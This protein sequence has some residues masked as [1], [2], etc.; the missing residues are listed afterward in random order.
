MEEIVKLFRYDPLTGNLYWLNPT[1]RALKRQRNGLSA[2][3]L[4][5]SGYTR[6]EFR[7]K[8]YLAHRIVF[9]MHHGYVPNCIDHIN[10][11]PSDNRIENLREATKTQNSANQKMRGGSSRF[12]GAWWCKDKKKWRASIKANGKQN[13]IGY[14]TSELDAAK[15]Y[16]EAALKY[17]GEFARLNEI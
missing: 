10:G 3:S 13:H 7:G 5:S 12:K 6:I 16:N 15:A 11:C 8:R 14:F 1:G 17:F 4:G 2:G 9:Y